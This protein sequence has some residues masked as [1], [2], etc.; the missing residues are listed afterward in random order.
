MRRWTLIAV[1]VVMTTGS[2]WPLCAAD[3]ESL[4]RTIKSVDREGRGNKAAGQAVNELSQQG[5]TVLPAVLKS[6]GDANP[7]AANYLRGAV[8]AI[9]DRALK[10]GKPLP[11]RQ[12][13][14]LIRDK[15]QD[16]RARRLAF[17]LLSR[18]DASAPDRLIPGMLLD[19]SPDFRR[20]AVARL[21]AS[22]EKLLQDNDTDAAKGAFKKALSG[23]TDDDQVKAI[24]KRLKELREEVDLKRHFGFLTDWQ[25]IGPFDNVGLKGFDTVYPPEERL[26]LAAKLEGQKGP[27]AWES[28]STDDE[29]G[30]FNIAKTIAPHKGAAMYAVTEFHSPTDRIVEFRLG[31]PNAW[32]LWLNGKQLFGRDEYHR[33]M[34]IDQYR[35]RGDL[36]PGA[37]TILLKICQNEQTEDWAQRYEFQLRVADLSGIGLLSQSLS[38][39]L[40]K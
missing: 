16:P 5:V 34:A 13:E 8:E 7:L 14:Q 21:I 32:K 37:N 2:S 15:E 23:A 24:V 10:S 9:A 1:L 26:D 38:T 36:K 40:G 19:P 35:V 31:T 27:V 33:G 4:L 12:L 3:T 17:E 22:G 18:V 6:F 28:F 11:S 25:F 30:I 39:P 20:D 29:Y